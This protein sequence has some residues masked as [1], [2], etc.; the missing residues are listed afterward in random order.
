LQFQY[1]VSL[2]AEALLRIAYLQSTPVFAMAATGKKNELLTRVK[3]M[4]DKKE[5]RFSYRKQL[6]SF[7]IVTGIL[8]SIA[9]LNPMTPHTDKQTATTT[10]S[11]ANRPKQPYAVEPMVVSVANPL[12]NPIFFLSEPLKEKM[13]ENL[14]SA[15]KEMD[16]AALEYVKLSEHP[17]ES[18]TPI[19]EDAMKQASVEMAMAPQ[20]IDLEKSMAKIETAK[21]DMKKMDMA[22]LFRFDSAWLPIKMRQKFKEDMNVSLKKMEVE[23]KNAKTEIER[24]FKTGSEI[25]FEKEKVQ[26]DIQKAMEAL[27]QLNKMGGLDNIVLNSLKIAGFNTDNSKPRQKMKQPSVPREENSKP[28]FR[29]FSPDKEPVKTNTETIHEEVEEIK[30]NDEEH[31]HAIPSLDVKLM[32]LLELAKVKLDA[33]TLIKLKTYLLEQAAL[34]ENRAKVTPVINKEKREV[35]ERKV[36]IHLQ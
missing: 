26:G 1:D 29:R 20:T 16:E 27:E 2:Y 4:I 3:R 30:M 36:I 31:P 32:P 9:W 18:L 8:S 13:K 22:K 21:M 6:L 5:N 11:L 14:A 34:Q 35:D 17:I 15:Q 25:V 23:I 10:G 19:V 24:S 28:R 12:F 33:A 7:V